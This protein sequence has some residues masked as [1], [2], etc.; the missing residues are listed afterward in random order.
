MP[1]SCLLVYC[2]LA[3]PRSVSLLLL[4]CCRPKVMQTAQCHSG[5]RTRANQHS[6]SS[7]C[8]AAHTLKCIALPRLCPSRARLPQQ[9][10]ILQSNFSDHSM[11]CAATHA[12]QAAQTEMQQQRP[13]PVDV[14]GFVLADTGGECP[15]GKLPVCWRSHAAPTECWRS[16][17]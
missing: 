5:V 1:T 4:S 17:A 16:A 6:S 14:T 2:N 11:I 9:H 13:K 10:S 12:G 7:Q 8:Q 3:H 15:A